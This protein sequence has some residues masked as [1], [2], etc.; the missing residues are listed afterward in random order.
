[1]SF[2]DNGKQIDKMIV[3]ITKFSN[4]L[5]HNILKGMLKHIENKYKK[6]Y[7]QDGGM[8]QRFRPNS[9][10]NITTSQLNNG[11]KE[12]QNR[13]KKEKEEEQHTNHSNDINK[14]KIALEQ[15]EMRMNERFN[16]HADV[17]DSIN[18]GVQR[19]VET[20]ADGQEKLKH[21]H[22]DLKSG[23]SEL[24][25]N[26][27]KNNNC[28][29]VSVAGFGMG[30]ILGSIAGQQSSN[31]SPS[32][33]KGAITG[34]ILGSLYECIMVMMSI[35]YH[36]S[37]F[38]MMCYINI[39]K[40]IFLLNKL[41]PGE[42]PYLGG[43][44]LLVLLLCQ[45]NLNLWLWEGIGKLIGFE[46]VVYSFSNTVNKPILEQLWD[47]GKE[48]MSMCKEMSS[49]FFGPLMILFDGLTP[50]CD[51]DNTPK[52][53]K[54]RFMY[55]ISTMMNS[56]IYDCILSPICCAAQTT[57]MGVTVNPLSFCCFTESAPPPSQP[58]GW[59][60]GGG[61]NRVT[62]YSNNSRH[63][64]N[65]GLLKPGHDFINVM[66]LL[67]KIHVDT[68]DLKQLKKTYVTILEKNMDVCSH[69]YNLTDFFRII[70]T[71]LS[72]RGK[73]LEYP[74]GNNMLA[75]QH[76]RKKRASKKRASKRASKKRASKRASKRRAKYY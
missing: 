71:K 61:G 47:M 67:A 76:T 74:E 46:S 62:H 33:G 17:L 54:G 40:W 50:P 15:F 26:L 10:K 75:L 18:T 45:I 28:L 16:V 59:W 41:G 56:I 13:I 73:I 44:I 27:R 60:G 29:N 20:L 4:T 7:K 55:C 8:R 64:N 34:A 42:T 1:M 53:G 52:I 3:K 69:F 58:T 49:N 70:V 21:I 30:L 66:R 14:I 12:I 63:R 43:L 24:N 37:S 22:K 2:T 51:G 11:I 19:N 72:Q 39:N 6:D 65:L 36:I 5:N 48:I 35:L 32:I 31:N 68:P 25:D 9:N 23:F 38:I 57:K